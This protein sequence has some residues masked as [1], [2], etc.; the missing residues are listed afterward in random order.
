MTQLYSTLASI[1]HEMYQHIF[2][3]DDEF[4]FYDTIMKKYDCHKIL[5]IGCGSGM[6]AR[7][8]LNND[9]EYMGLDLSDEMLEI[10]RTEINTGKFVQ[11]D[12]RTLPFI[13]QF[14][15]TLITGRSISYIIKNHEIIDTL[16]GIHRALKDKGLLVFDLFEA[17]GIFENLKD[18]KQDIRNKGKRI[19]R[20]SKLERNLRTGWTWDWK[21]KY[22]IEDKGKTSEY[23]DLTTLRAFTKDEIL[24]FLKLTKFEILDIIEET[25]A[26][27]IVARKI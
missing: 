22:I 11:G 24:L 9:Y 23:E 25:K 16:T 10:A 6:L 2:N 13:N 18:F 27:N 20:I 1:Y 21:A 17:F 4:N 15:C 19:Q 7:H 14:D 8:L 5:E 26:M 3:Y 12:M